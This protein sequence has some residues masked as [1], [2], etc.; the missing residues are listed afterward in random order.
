MGFSFV[1]LGV[2]L[3]RLLAAMPPALGV[4]MGRLLGTLLFYTARDRRLVCERNISISFPELTSSEQKKLVKE[5]FIQNGVGLTETAWSWHRPIGFI[6]DKV[7]VS[8]QELVHA[9]R[10]NQAGI[11]L[12]SLIHI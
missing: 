10:E 3:V 12:L 9:A 6:D 4:A 11:L 8:G 7:V 2:G 1:P 5:C